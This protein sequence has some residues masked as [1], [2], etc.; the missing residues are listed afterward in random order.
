MAGVS[1]AGTQ[2]S[3]GSRWQGPASLGSRWQGP[4]SDLQPASG[5]QCTYPG[6]KAHLRITRASLLHVSSVSAPQVVNID[7]GLGGAFAAFRILRTV[8]CRSALPCRLRT[9]TPQHPCSATSSRPL[10]LSSSL[11]SQMS[12]S[13]AHWCISTVSNS[14]RNCHAAANSAGSLNQR[15]TGVS[16]GLTQIKPA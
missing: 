6:T 16:T 10:M 12:M 14:R 5:L 9:T 8:R 2:L 1:R 4:A 11:G 13:T 7:N 15:G 3:L